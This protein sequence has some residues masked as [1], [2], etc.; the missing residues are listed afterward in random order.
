MPLW[1]SVSHYAA[2]HIRTETSNEAA[3][4]HENADSSR[5]ELHLEAGTAAPTRI[6]MRENEGQEGP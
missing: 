1:R 5:F 3:T 6:Q 4:R 2:H